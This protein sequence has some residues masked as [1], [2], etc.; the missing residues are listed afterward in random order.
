MK[1]KRFAWFPK[2]VNTWRPQKTKAL[3]WL[4]YYYEDYEDTNHIFKPKLIDK[5]CN[6]LGF[7]GYEFYHL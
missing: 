1:I 3:I 7:W 4:Q 5:Y 6:Y 2:I